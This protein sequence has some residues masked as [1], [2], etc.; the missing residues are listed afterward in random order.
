M[1]NEA[2]VK[3][4][5]KALCRKHNAYY[6]MPQGAGYGRAG[7]PDFLICQRG[8]FIAVETKFGSNKATP[9]QLQQLREIG[10]SGGV[11]LVITEVNL[12]LLDS[13][14]GQR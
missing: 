7:V 3:R 10:Q 2:D 14:L 12:D 5:V 6:A 9:M 13:V 11:A 4:Q 8:R 1:K